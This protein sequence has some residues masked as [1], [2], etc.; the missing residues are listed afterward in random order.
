MLWVSESNAAL[1]HYCIAS[2]PGLTTHV[3][4]E[5]SWSTKMKPLDLPTGEETRHDGHHTTFLVLA[6][7]ELHEAEVNDIPLLE[8]R[9]GPFRALTIIGARLCPRCMP[10]HIKQVRNQTQR[11]ALVRQMIFSFSP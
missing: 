7:A 11:V 2:H 8:L 9:N 4:E 6:G 3:A 5:V 10:W 1:P